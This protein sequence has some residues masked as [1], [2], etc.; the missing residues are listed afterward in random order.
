MLWIRGWGTTLYDLLK[1]LCLL[2]SFADETASNWETEF[3]IYSHSTLFY[4]YIE[5]YDLLILL[6]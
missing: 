4:Y 3:S 2:Y 5:F 1:P 6:N